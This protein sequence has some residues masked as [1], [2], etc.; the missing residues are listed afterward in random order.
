VTAAKG[1]LFFALWPGEAV[2]SALTAA[3]ASAVAAAGGR[4]VPAQNLHLTLAFLGAVPA[5]A[6]APLVALGAGLELPQAD[7]TLDRL[8]WWPRA[9]VLVAAASEPPAALIEL[10]ADVRRRLNDA[11]F[12]IDSQ[13]FR[14]HVT[15][16]RKVASPP[17]AVASAVVWPIAAA[18]L[19]ES[20]PAPGGSRYTPLATWARGG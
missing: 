15:L 7:V 11:G 16:A 3:F 4:A 17:P 10:Q 6:Q 20:V 14:P 5:E 12:H 9:E 8:D 19:V 18:A 13:P 1:R 2:R